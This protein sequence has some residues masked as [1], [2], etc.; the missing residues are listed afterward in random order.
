MRGST[1][2]TRCMHAN[3]R[4]ATFVRPRT[5]YNAKLRERHTHML[6]LELL[7][8]QRVSGHTYHLCGQRRVAAPGV[9]RG[10]A[11]HAWVACDSAGVTA[12]E[13]CARVSAAPAAA[14]RRPERRRVEQRSLVTALA[15]GGRDADYDDDPTSYLWAVHLNS[16][17][18]LLLS[19]GATAAEA[20]ALAVAAR[21]ARVPA[22]D[23]V[24]ALTWAAVDGCAVPPSALAVPDQWAFL[25][26]VI[27]KGTT[28]DAVTAAELLPRRGRCFQHLL[29]G[30]CRA[31]RLMEALRVLRHMRAAGPQPTLANYRVL[32]A[33]AGKPVGARSVSRPKLVLSLL[34]ELTFRGLELDTLTANV[35]FSALAG[36]P[37][38]AFSLYEEKLQDGSLKLDRISFNTMLSITA[39]KESPLPRD[40]RAVRVRQVLQDMARAACAPDAI[41]LASAVA[42]LG[43]AGAVDEAFDVWTEMR[44]GGVVPNSRCWTAML[45]AC[46]SARQYDRCHSLFTGMRAASSGGGG[47]QP[48]L[49]HWNVLI[50]TAVVCNLPETAFAL[51]EEMESVHN[52]E[53]DKY[54]RNCLLRAMAAQYGIDAAFAAAADLQLSAADWTMLVDLCAEAK[55]AKRA[56]ATLDMMREYGVNPDVVAF[57]ALI[58]AYANAGDSAGALA[59][60]DKLFAAG[61]RPNNNTFLAL[62][63]ACRAAND[64]ERAAVVYDLMR[65]AGVRPQITAFRSLLAAW[66]D[67]SVCGSGGVPVE[68]LPKWLL[69]AGNSEEG[70]SVLV[71]GASC[72][73]LHGLSTEEARALI[74]CRLRQLREV[75]IVD[76]APPTGMLIITGRGLNSD[77]GKTVLR[78]EAER[79]CSEL[80]LDCTDDES[81]PGRLLVPA[82][83]L[84]AW[85]AKKG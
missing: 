31:G 74:L 3:V 60:Y 21:A 68:Q 45:S 26:F 4:T 18:E 37:A 71:T 34:R 78:E 42:A 8:W 76:E 7:A 44:G 77:N 47:V 6:L 29:H 81:N 13:P 55:D 33:A 83:S 72:V 20:T 64:F 1:L 11:P 79:L 54:T 85:L 15:A 25:N 16:L 59:A 49:E 27:K 53:P 5:Q 61:L 75:A 43:S 67:A 46:R 14:F 84:R 32:M 19:P 82:D 63:R 73:D 10:A 2:R 52:V 66:V 69:E 40:Q 9:S 30:Y 70:C 56:A 80:R 24:N 50:D 48:S 28:N 22:A 51:A 36:A 65:Q 58:K 39:A 38:R 12:A 41:T 62:L 23:M 35:L 57:T 17:R